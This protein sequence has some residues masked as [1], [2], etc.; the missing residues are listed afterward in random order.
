MNKQQFNEVI[1]VS[2]RTY[3]TYHDTEYECMVTMVAMVT[4]VTRFGLLEIVA[5]GQ[6]RPLRHHIYRG[7]VVGV[8]GAAVGARGAVVGF[9]GQLSAILVCIPTSYLRPCAGLYLND[10]W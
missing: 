6:L 2:Y 10:R 8:R 9:R 1:Q 3:R 4:M 7:A 5:A